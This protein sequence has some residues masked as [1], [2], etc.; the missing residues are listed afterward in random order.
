M[1]RALIFYILIAAMVAVV[2]AIA[3]LD[4]VVTIT[5]WNK[6]A[7]V[8]VQVAIALIVGLTFLTILVYRIVMSFVDAPGEFFRWRA[9]GKRRRGFTAITRGLV[10][11]AAGD[12]EEARRQTK[13]AISLVGEPPLAML[14]AA[15][16]A[17]LEGDDEG[18]Q[19]Y[20]TQMLQSK[21]TEFLGLRGLYVAATR[22]GDADQAIQI[23]ERARTLRPR[24]RW[25]L[26]ALFDLHSAKG[27]WGP[28][29][30]IVDGQVRAKL[31]DAGIARRRR[32]VLAAA[33]AQDA[34]R[35]GDAE[36]AFARAQDAHALAPG[37][38]PAALIAAKH[39]AAQ[40][41][42]WKAQSLIETAWAQEPHPDLAKAYASLKPEEPPSSRAKRLLQ[43]VSINP[44][45]PE[46]Q[47]LSAA[48][49]IAASRFEEA[50]ETLR[51]LAERF[52]V[53]RVCLLM[54]EVEQGFGNDESLAAREWT[55]RAQRA[56]RDAHWTC[57][58]CARTHADWSATCISCGA[59]DT[60]SW[61]S[62]S[63]GAVETMSPS[64]TA[65]AYPGMAENPNVLYRDAIKT[66]DIRPPART[67][68]PSSDTMRDVSPQA[69][70]PMFHGPPGAPDDPGPDADDDWL[71]GDSR[72]KS[73]TW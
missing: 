69:R 3:D 15:Q 13:K 34:E 17:Q 7:R 4:G 55:V 9:S 53:A 37:F 36:V 14:L 48:V 16:A 58:A 2:T 28:A 11:V 65:A 66:D 32:A 72:R 12:E 62:G 29:A 38:A 61:Q 50:R 23:A 64:E 49:S 10:A 54:A 1:I 5:M 8:P 56:P 60:L 20:F 26:N 19:R 63:R 59:F 46:S 67:A 40:G 41:R 22:R 70:E 18:A 39:F 68:A 73:G 21:E 27:A 35:K 25:A 52:P 51:P 6:E 42:Q 45:H 57:S 33:A 24:T 71:G 30:D 43:L 44:A 47:I 31:L